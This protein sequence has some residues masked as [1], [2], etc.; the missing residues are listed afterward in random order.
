MA[1]EI[2]LPIFEGPLDLLLFLIKKSEIDIY[3]IPVARIT[4]EYLHYIE[5]LRKLNLELA[6][7]FIL[8]A[9]TLM[10]IKAAMLLPA[11][12]T[13]GDDAEAPEDPRQKLVQSLLEYQQFK[14]VAEEL[15]GIEED[16]RKRFHRLVIERFE[17]TEEPL[18]L[19]PG[20]VTVFDLI[21]A[22][23]QVLIDM[24][25][26]QVHSIQR[27]T[28]DVDERIQFIKTALAVQPRMS[29]KDLI[30]QAP[31]R[32]S[33]IV[34]FLA[35]LELA[36]QRQ[37]LLAQGNKFQDI[38]INRVVVDDALMAAHQN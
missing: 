10:R 31:D 1:Y 5:M 2:K 13:T 12:P 18:D 30:R 3:D 32:L 4:K 38:W 20:T 9:G 29:F 26:A 24:P 23:Q 34:T 35:I 11:P 15:G 27:E 22:L 14:E 6:G 16:A 17:D 36:K 8:M 37:V 33:I 19:L 28:V 7:D 25:S 21:T